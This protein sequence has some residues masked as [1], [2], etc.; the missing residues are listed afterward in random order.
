MARR[1]RRT[2]SREMTWVLYKTI[3]NVGSVNEIMCTIEGDYPNFL[4]DDGDGHTIFNRPV[5]FRG[6][7]WAGQWAYS[8]VP[9]T[10]NSTGL[11][12]PFLVA[13]G[14]DTAG[15]SPVLENTPRTFPMVG[16]GL[17]AA[18]VPQSTMG[19]FDIRSKS[20]RKIARG[21]VAFCQVKFVNPVLDDEQVSIHGYARVLY[22]VS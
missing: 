16:P 10:N 7:H 9:P 11:V 19:Y 15:A 8:L 20:M 18:G 22:E 21:D 6:G 1:I 3:M 5:L 4:V 2:R 17:V 14:F 12:K 13:W